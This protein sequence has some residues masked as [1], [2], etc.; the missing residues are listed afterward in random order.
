MVKVKSIGQICVLVKDLD[1]A[2]KKYWEI[3]GIGPW[4]FYT[5]KAPWLR[6][7]TFFGK[8]AD[9]EF[10]V[11][12]A[13]MDNTQFELIQPVKG[14]TIYED[15]L[16]RKGEGLHH[17][18]EVVDDVPKAAAEYAKMGFKV[19]QSGKFG[20]DEFA[21]L[22]TESTLGI[23]LELGNMAAET[24]KGLPPPDKTYP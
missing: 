24:G 7:A 15:F 5:L 13:K 22:D 11:A 1:S 23:S 10:R 17:I 8:P 9:P 14:P 18:K 20:V 16:K 3:L 12:V 19:I 21:Y 6:D 4:T 2:V